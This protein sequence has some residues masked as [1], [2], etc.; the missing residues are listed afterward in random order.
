MAQ[1]SR[2]DKSIVVLYFPHAI[3]SSIPLNRGSAFLHPSVLCEGKELRHGILIERET[4]T[5]L[6][7]QL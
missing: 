3:Q 4:K 1:K 5:V 6:A 7:S 2:T